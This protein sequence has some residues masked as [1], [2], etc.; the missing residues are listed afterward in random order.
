MTLPPRHSSPVLLQSLLKESYDL[1]Y[2]KSNFPL[3]LK[4]S[5]VILHQCIY[6][7]DLAVNGNFLL[8]FYKARENGFTLNFCCETEVLLSHKN[9]VIIGKGSFISIT[10]YPL[11]F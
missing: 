8:Y 5:F 10:T 7:S 9:T 2:L 3:F 11:Y 4:R 6:P 1:K